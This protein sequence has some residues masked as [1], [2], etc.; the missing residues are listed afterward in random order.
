VHKL[1]LFK[2][3]GKCGKCGRIFWKRRHVPIVMMGNRIPPEMDTP[4][5]GSQLE[6]LKVR[7]P[8]EI[9]IERNCLIAT[10]YHKIRYYIVNRRVWMRL[11]KASTIII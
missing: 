7:D 9:Q 11:L 3:I 4:A 1:L 2:Q 8:C 10:L 6:V 5:F